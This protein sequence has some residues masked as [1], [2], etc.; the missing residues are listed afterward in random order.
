M[1]IKSDVSAADVV[2][3]AVLMTSGPISCRLMLLVAV[4]VAGAAATAL[5]VACQCPRLISYD[6]GGFVIPK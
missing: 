5:A 2:A 1:L 3:V 6:E 4:T